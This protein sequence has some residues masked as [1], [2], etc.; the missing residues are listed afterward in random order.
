M[1]KKHITAPFELLV[2]IVERGKSEKVSE[3]LKVHDCIFTLT[4]LG[5]GTAR[6]EAADIFGFGIVDRD[7]VWALVNPL[8]SQRILDTLNN[9]LELNQPQRGIAMCIPINS[10]SNLML[11]TLGINY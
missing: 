8:M 9:V 10:A 11:D 3:I 1:K 4:T 2:A 5:Q 6:S 7:V